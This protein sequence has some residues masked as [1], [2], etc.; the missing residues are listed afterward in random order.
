[1][2]ATAVEAAPGVDARRAADDRERPAEGLGAVGRA[3]AGS[4]SVAWSDVDGPVRLIEVSGDPYQM[5]LQLGRFERERIL[6]LMASCAGTFEF[7]SSRLADLEDVVAHRE[8]YWGEDE[9][10]ELEGMAEGCGV[11]VES[12]AAL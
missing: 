4:N 5:G 9:W 12:L 8:A 1:E 11:P 3:E 2:S 10:R 6:E 7:S